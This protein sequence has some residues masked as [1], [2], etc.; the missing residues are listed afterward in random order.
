MDVLI[1]MGMNP[2]HVN[3]IIYIYISNEFLFLT[4]IC[5]KILPRVQNLINL[6][7][8]IINY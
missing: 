6:S 5:A 3:Y 8:N 1:A 4:H 7:H 2:K